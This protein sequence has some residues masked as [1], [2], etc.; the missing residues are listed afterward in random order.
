MSENESG[1]DPE[2]KIALE[3][4]ARI[5]HAAAK[6]YMLESENMEIHSWDQLPDE[7]RQ[8]LMQL[9]GAYMLDPDSPRPK[10]NK[11][12]MIIDRIFHAVITEFVAATDDGEVQS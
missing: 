6:A 3:F 5:A 1:F 4:M 11:Q 7:G 9:A 10:G 8:D 12:I 2:R